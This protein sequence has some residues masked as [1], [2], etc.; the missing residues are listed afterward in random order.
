[1]NLSETLQAIYE[2]R[3]G[4][5]ELTR[6]AKRHGV[7]SAGVLTVFDDETAALIALSL[8]ERIE[9]KTIIEIGGGIGL[10]AF[11]LGVFAER[12]YCIEANPDWAWTFASTLIKVKPKHVSYLFG[13]ADEFVGLKADVAL[14]CTHS[15]VEA[16]NAAGRLFAPEVI[17]IYGEI[18]ASDPTKFDSIARE[19]RKVA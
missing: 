12:V 7:Q 13:A 10:L 6:Y 3:E 19:L 5:E 17:D 14:F 18:I 9:G 16:M 15:G 8:Q 4:S 2:A 11:H 1:M